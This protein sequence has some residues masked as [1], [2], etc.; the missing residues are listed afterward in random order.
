MSFLIGLV[1]IMVGAPVVGFIGTWIEDAG[2]VTVGK[3]VSVGG[4]LAVLGVAAWL[5]ISSF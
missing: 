4:Y 3:T 5:I 1:L 2:Y